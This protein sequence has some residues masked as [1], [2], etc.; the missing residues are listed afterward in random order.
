MKKPFFF[1]LI[2]TL[3]NSVLVINMQ[4]QNMAQDSLKQR[5]SEEKVGYYSSGELRYRG[6]FKEGQPFGIFKYFF[7]T[8]EL[9]SIVEHLGEGKARVTHYYQTGDTMA[10]GEYLNQKKHGHWITYGAKGLKVNEGNYISDQKYE[11]WKTYY[12]NG[13]LAEEISFKANLED[14]PYRT[15][16]RNGKP[17]QEG[18]Y[19]NGY[20]K[21]KTRFYY[22]S[23][24]LKSV[25]QYEKDVKDGEWI[26]YDE[27]G[28]ELRRIEYKQGYRLTPLSEGE[29]T[30]SYEEFEDQVKD[31][32][33]F[34]DMQG[35]IKYNEQ[36]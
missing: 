2:L 11:T 10:K 25:G 29:K 21:G 1:S 30:G 12:P 18:T 4:A 9:Q 20:R 7:K 16:Y 22:S 15:F 34:E 26:Y 36:D 28:N 35:K 19:F 32:L 17:S 8:G 3:L 33:E 23:G 13:I 24:Q 6:Q 27:E 31:D 14:G 5:L